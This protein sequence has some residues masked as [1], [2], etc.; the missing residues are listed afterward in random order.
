MC[1][2]NMNTNK[3]QIDAQINPERQWKYKKKKNQ[4]V[5]LSQ[6]LTK[7]L[8]ENNHLNA[9]YLP[10]TLLYRFPTILELTLPLMVI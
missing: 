3:A 10:P 8:M 4:M 1:A 7:K 6:N 2:Q 5:D 9:L